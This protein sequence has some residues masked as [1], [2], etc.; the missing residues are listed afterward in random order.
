MKKELKM[1]EA[2]ALINALNSGVVPKLGIQ[3][4]VVGR[5]KEISAMLNHID[6]VKMGNSIFKFWIGEYGSGKSFMLNL[7]RII[8]LKQDFVVS[9]VDLNSNRRLYG[10]NRRAVSTYT[11][12]IKNISIKTKP[13]G[14]A[15]KIILEKWIENLF[16]KISDEKNIEISKLRN[17]S[18]LKTIQ[19][20]VFK[21][22]FSLTE[23]NSYDFSIILLKYIKG[24]LMEEDYLQDYVLKWIKGEYITKTDARRDLGVRKIINDKNY[25][26]MLKNLCSFFVNIG[27]NGF[28]INLDEGINLYKITLSPSRKKNY[29]MILNI[30]NDCVQGNVEHLFFNIAGVPKFLF[31]KRRGLYCDGALKSRLEPNEF[32]TDNFKD[33]EQPVLI[34][35]TL[36]SEDIFVL[37]QKILFTY[38]FR[39]SIE[40]K[41]KDS[42]IKDFINYIYSQNL[43]KNKITPRSFIRKFLDLLKMIKQNPKFKKDEFFDNTV[44]QNKNFN[45]EIDDISGIE[46]I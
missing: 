18:Y 27:F 35:E 37:L 32:E 19:E 10:S 26:D 36:K 38:N 24:Y 45:D 28:M 16:L 4:I 8:A 34:L 1:K 29:D 40:I 43:S 3:N 46:E 33:L 30:F 14:N 15:L 44:K 5:D 9:S 42:E 2:V 39:Y 25:Y 13:D 23:V 20:Y 6:E 22:I 21:N 41:F 11:E 17:I 7:L 12:L 31:E